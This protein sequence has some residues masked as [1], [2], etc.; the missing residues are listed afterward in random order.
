MLF[1]LFKPSLFGFVVLTVSMSVLAESVAKI[2]LPGSYSQI[3]EQRKNKS[4]ILILWSLDCPSCY[5]E[6]EM[7]GKFK[8]EH[9]E[10]DMV[11]VS[12]DINATQDELQIVLK[13][14]KLDKVESWVFSGDSEERLR[15]EID[16]RWY[17]DLPRSYFFKK[18]DEKQLVSGIIIKEKLLAW[19]KQ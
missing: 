17:G 19:M 4:F 1:K 15:F 5:K 7:L 10:I 9:S 14:Y 13:K 11:L 12:T 2:F 16:S 18:T 3:L 8:E 6:L